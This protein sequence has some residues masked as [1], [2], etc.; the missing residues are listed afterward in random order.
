MPSLRGVRAVGRK[1]GTA[2]LDRAEHEIERGAS[3]SGASLRGANASGMRAHNERLVLSLLRRDGPMAK[4][5]IARATGLSNQAVSVIVRAL[6]AD[7]LIARGEPVRGRIGQPSVP[8]RL[9]GDGAYFFGLKIGRRSIELALVDFL[10]TVVAAERMVWRYPT[11]DAVIA[12]VRER[13]PTLRRRL[14]AARRKRLVGLGIAIP[15]QLWNWGAYLGAPAGALEDWR[16]RDIAG[17]IAALTELPVTLQN[18]A[19]AA[20]G[21]ELV[22]GTGERLQ[23]ALTIYFGFFIGGGLVLNGHLFTGRR[24]NAAG[25]GPLP[26]PG[27][28]GGSVPLLSVASLSALAARIARA[29]GDPERLWQSPDGWDLSPAVREDFVAASAGGLASAILSASALLELDAVVIEGWMPADLRADIVARTHEAFQRLD[30]SGIESLQIRAGTVGP[31]ARVLGSA[32][33][34]LAQ[35]YLVD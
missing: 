26:V 34:P 29:G 17:E 22:F 30:L 28:G 8:M 14:P 2:G 6:E 24:G 19:T 7:G 31:H 13:L 3:A 4:T 25:L 35:R 5:E 20:C 12:F 21:A 10:G 18:D 1:A 15:F 16:T 23:N 32:A 33:I 27:P 11:P 9:A